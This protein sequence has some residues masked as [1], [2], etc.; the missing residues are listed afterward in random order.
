MKLPAVSWTFFGLTVIALI[1][2]ALSLGSF[3]GSDAVAVRMP[4]GDYMYSYECVV[5]LSRFREYQ[6]STLR[7]ADST[8][9]HFVRAR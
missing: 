5:L 6:Q 7:A 4:G 2:Y 3:I 1:I 8:V 9:S